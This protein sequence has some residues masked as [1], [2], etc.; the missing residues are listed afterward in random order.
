MKD[1]P[2]AGE[3]SEW[4]FVGE[5]P[6]EEGEE[7][8]TTTNEEESPSPC[9]VNVD[10]IEWIEGLPTILLQVRPSGLVVNLSGLPVYF[11]HDNST[12][13]GTRISHHGVFSPANISWD[14]VIYILII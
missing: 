12:S 9:L 4:P 11:A 3:D 1:G 13:K 5:S 8:T 6:G 2:A 14:N 10:F 7:W